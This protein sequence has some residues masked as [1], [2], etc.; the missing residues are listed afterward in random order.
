EAEEARHSDD[1]QLGQER[2]GVTVGHVLPHRLLTRRGAQLERRRRHRPRR[3][4]LIEGQDDGLVLRDVGDA[5]SRSRAAE[6]AGDETQPL[7]SVA[8]QTARLLQ[9]RG[10]AAT[11]AADRGEQTGTRQH[12]RRAVAWP[13]AVTVAATRWDGAEEHGLELAEE[14][15]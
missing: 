3:D 13:L 7:R 15:R 12:P 9:A 2:N 1:A 5:A 6:I 4:V 10:A 11:R 8:L 14:H